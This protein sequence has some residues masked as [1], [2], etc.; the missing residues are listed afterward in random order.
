MSHYYSEKPDSELKLRKV[1]ELIRGKELVFYLASGVFSA[2]RIDNGSRLLAEDSLIEPNWD[3]LDLGCGNGI[4]GI[5][6]AKAELSAK[7]LLTDINERAV[8]ATKLNIKLNHADNATAKKSDGL[9]KLN[10]LFDTILFNPPQ[11]AGRELCKA[12]IEEA[13]AHLKPGG[14][15]QLVARHN[16]GGKT[17]Y[18]FMQELF[19]NGEVVSKSGGYRIYL[20]K[21]A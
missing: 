20:C 17:L 18:N 16:K 13:K 14:S 11:T 5:A 9:K 3:V 8:K 12:L 21:N 15:L 4:V 1:N 7:V 10:N 6:V 19:G 2:K